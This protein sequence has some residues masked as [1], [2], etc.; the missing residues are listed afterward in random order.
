MRVTCSIQ[1]LM[2]NKAFAKIQKFHTHITKRIGSGYDFLQNNFLACSEQS[3][4]CLLVQELQTKEELKTLSLLRGTHL[5]QNLHRELQTKEELRRQSE[6]LGTQRFQHIQQ[7]QEQEHPKQEGKQDENN[8]LQV[9]HL[10]VE[11]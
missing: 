10:R 1:F 9:R 6:L 2:G 5:S 11:E 4:L 3:L 7:E 8:V